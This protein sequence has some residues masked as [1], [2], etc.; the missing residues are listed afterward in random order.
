MAEQMLSRMH[1]RMRW[2]KI[3]AKQISSNG[4]IFKVY[5][6]ILQLNIKRENN[7]IFTTGKRL[8]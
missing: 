4:L 6:E 1:R 7:M 3:L 2:E 5:K 8:K